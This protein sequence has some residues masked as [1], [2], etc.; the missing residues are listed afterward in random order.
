MGSIWLEVFKLIFFFK[1]FNLKNCENVYILR[2]QQLGVITKLGKTSFYSDWRRLPYPTQWKICMFRV[3]RTRI[4]NTKPHWVVK[5]LV[6]LWWLSIICSRPWP[7]LQI[8]D[9]RPCEVFA[10]TTIG[11]G[12]FLCVY[13]DLSPNQTQTHLDL[14]CERS[15]H[16]P[17]LLYV[18]SIE[19][20]PWCYRGEQQNP[21][22]KRI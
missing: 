17:I 3:S 10:C 11:R 12:W 18:E 19:C 22:L 9:L 14:E 16:I 6:S 21:D 20:L 4:I 13:L 7:K 8:N 5:I 15:R 2:A 1:S